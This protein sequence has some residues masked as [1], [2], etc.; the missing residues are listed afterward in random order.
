MI[1]PENPISRSLLA[2]PYLLV[3]YG[4]TLIPVR[5]YCAAN[6]V[7]L[8]DNQKTFMKKILKYNNI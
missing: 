3:I 5:H 6:I 2:V 4:I 7:V 8:F 1:L